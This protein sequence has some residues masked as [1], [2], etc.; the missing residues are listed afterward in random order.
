[1][2]SRTL[3]LDASTAILL[4]KV[5]LLRDL[6]AHGEA[7]M[8]ETAVAEALAK[9]TED[10]RAIRRLIEEGRIVS[11]RVECELEDL[12]RDFRLHAGELESIAPGRE[13]DAICATD[14]GPTIRCCKVLG[15]EFATAIGFLLALTDAGRIDRQVALEVL[16]E[17][18][19]VGRY[20][21]RIVEDATRRIRSP[22]AR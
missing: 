11:I 1:M 2:G 4:A 12:R 3:V 13:R 20:D 14:D 22:R 6:V 9:D 8:A 7:L 15:V 16:S 17:L 5:G 10:A 21:A 19:R 18:E